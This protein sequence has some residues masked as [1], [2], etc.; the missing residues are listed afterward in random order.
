M[1]RTRQKQEALK[2]GHLVSLQNLAGNHP[3]KWDNTG[4]IVEVKQ[5]DMPLTTSTPMEK[6]KMTESEMGTPLLKVYKDALGRDALYR[7]TLMS[8]PSPS[9]SS[10]ETFYT[11]REEVTRPSPATKVMPPEASSPKVSK[12]SLPTSQTPTVKPKEATPEKIIATPKR[13]T[14]VKPRVLERSFQVQVP[15]QLKSFNK[16]GLQEAE[17]RLDGPRQTRSGLK[18]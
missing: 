1:E 17:V 10:D 11:P 13:Q 6:I 18:R 16:P 5:N 15:K 12:G 8:G 3:L 9:T 4:V 14:V 7:K 2:V